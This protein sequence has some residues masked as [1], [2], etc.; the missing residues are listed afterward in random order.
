MNVV[1]M[2]KNAFKLLAWFEISTY[3]S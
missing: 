3:S 2:Q 1:G